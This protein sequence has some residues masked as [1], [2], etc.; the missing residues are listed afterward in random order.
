MRWCLLLLLAIACAALDIDVRANKSGK[1]SYAR[2]LAK[3]K[4]FFNVTH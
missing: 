1:L 2:Y 4:N 3:V